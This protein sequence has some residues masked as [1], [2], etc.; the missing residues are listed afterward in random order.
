M[1]K[2]NSDIKIKSHFKPKKFNNCIDISK[3]NV[4]AQTKKSKISALARKVTLDRAKRIV[5]DMDMSIE[6]LTEASLEY[7]VWVLSNKNIK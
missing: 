4:D 1:K 7:Y 3:G 5:R 6:E 2:T